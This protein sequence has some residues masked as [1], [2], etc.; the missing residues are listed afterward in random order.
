MQ[1]DVHVVPQRRASLAAGEPGRVRRLDWKEERV[2]WETCGTF[3][4]GELALTLF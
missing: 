1:D 2:W 3:C 4:E